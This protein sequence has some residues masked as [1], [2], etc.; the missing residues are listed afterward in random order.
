[1]DS[2]HQSRRSAAPAPAAS[3]A[4]RPTITPVLP[5]LLLETMRDM[6]RPEEVLE[7]EDLTISLPRRLGLSD[8][9]LSQIRRFQ[10]EVKHKRLQRA[11]DVEDLIRLVVRRPDAE[12]IFF[13]A[14]RRMA[15]HAFEQR[16]PG[17]RATV[18]IMPRALALLTAQRAAK[19]LFRRIAGPSGL[20][21]TRRPL[22][23]RIADALTVRADP[24]GMAC[25]LY[26][27][28][29]EEL[30]RAYTRRNYRVVHTHCRARGEDGCQ[31]QVLLSAA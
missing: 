14:G 31:W 22:E 16:A 29:F 12:E 26:T 2:S 15:Q 23:L 18:R 28:A 5:L 17:L 4:S 1:M 13:E 6:D 9:V 8:V 30:L 19:R 20:K 25:A 21:I 3:S 27:G 10:A 24:G 11:E 7:E